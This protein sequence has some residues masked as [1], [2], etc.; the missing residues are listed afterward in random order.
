MIVADDLQS[1]GLRERLSRLQSDVRSWTGNDLQLV[2]HAVASWRKLVR[3]KNALVEQI[4][5]DGSHWPAMPPRCSSAVDE[6]K[7][8]RHAR[9]LM[10]RV[11]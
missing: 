11:G 9:R 6:S 5:L 1:P 8:A 3:S 2:E 10:V 4:R 7:A